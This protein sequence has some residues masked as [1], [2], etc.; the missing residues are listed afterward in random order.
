MKNLIIPASKLNNFSASLISN[1]SIVAN[2]R[3]NSLQIL[4]TNDLSEILPRIASN[5][6]VNQHGGNQ[7]NLLSRLKIGLGI[8]TLLV[9][10]F[11]LGA[12]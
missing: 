7:Q 3:L 4:K 10:F 2:L 8:I 1:F 6:S 9:T 11:T 12:I 5:T